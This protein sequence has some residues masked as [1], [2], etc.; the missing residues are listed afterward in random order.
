MA[1]CEGCG[2]RVDE[3]HVQRRKERL[4]LAARFRPTKI[5]VLVLDSAPRGAAEDY[6]YRAVSDRTV[7]SVTGR[8]YFDELVKC[9]GTK[10]AKIDEILSLNEF[11]N[12]GFFLNYGVECPI[13]N[14]GELLNALRR[15]A[16]TIVKR[17]QYLLQPTYIVPISKGTEELIRLFGLIGWGDRLVLD[18]GGPFVDPYLGD[19]ERQAVFATSFGDRISKALAALP[20]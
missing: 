20:S 9:M 11:R 2:A 18:K 7:R 14:K 8:M 4:E 12:K 5:K 6:F 10:I 17:V 13:E 3:A 19:P 1:I 16:P 15:L